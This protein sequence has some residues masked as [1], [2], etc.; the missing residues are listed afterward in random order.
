M[1]GRSSQ[2]ELVLA[3]FLSAKGFGF[4]IFD[5]PG[6]LVDWGVKGVCGQKKNAQ[7]LRKVRELL[8]FYRPDVVVLED[9][10]GRGSRR[11]KR[12]RKLID[13]IATL[14]AKGRIAAASFSRAEVRTCF[15]RTTKR[16]IA[17]AIARDFPELEPWLPPVRRIWMSEDARMN[18]FDAVA[19]GVTFF[20]TMRKQKRAA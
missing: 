16:Q 13:A 9:C 19:L 1:H 10:D 6:S 12:I 15:G 14:V 8:T 11:T 17:L 5:G 4:A 3:V 2:K 7:S 20:H 18:I